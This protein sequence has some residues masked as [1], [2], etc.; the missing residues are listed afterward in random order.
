MCRAAQP[1][2]PE[3]PEAVIPFVSDLLRAEHRHPGT[4]CWQDEEKQVIWELIEGSGGTSTPQGKGALQLAA[5][6][7]KRHASEPPQI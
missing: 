5:T 2:L 1:A 4:A 6:I 3:K 7:P